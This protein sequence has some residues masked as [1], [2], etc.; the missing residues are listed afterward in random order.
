MR[1]LTAA[2]LAASLT[3]PAAAVE[4]GGPRAFDFVALGDMPYKLP[5]DYP[6]FEALIGRINALKPAFS[7]FIGDIKSGSSPCTDEN[8]LKV[9]SE[10]DLF[11]QPVAYSVGDNE[12]TDC[13]RERAGK[14]D[15]M[16]RLTKLRGWFFGEAKTQGKV[17]MDVERM[18]DVMPE[19][20]ATDGNGFVEITRFVKNGVMFIL[21]HVPGSNNNFEPRNVETVQE[22][23]ARNKAN[24]AWINASFA[25]AKAEN[26]SA[27]VIG[28]QAEMQD[29]KQTE[30][31]TPVASGFVD[32][33]QAI[34]KGAKAFGKPIL[35]VH[36]DNH[37]LRIGSFDGTD[38][39]PVPNVT[40]LQVMGEAIV[41][42]VRVIVD[43][44]NV[45]M[46]F[47]FQPMNE[48]PKVTN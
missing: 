29:I 48:P 47:A 35:V 23:F 16:E 24:V 38:Y 7:L 15:P 11:E 22:Y 2:I 31:A 13:H 5:D 40:R 18:A 26:L 30:P 12:W 27:V 34:E 32:T 14:F 46:P 28:L 17:K 1:M 20:K 8:I 21:P 39:K 37:V 9:K 3:V 44:D 19:F 33:I 4:V 25:K 43:P 10:F 42:A 41:G 6:R 36:G 45:T